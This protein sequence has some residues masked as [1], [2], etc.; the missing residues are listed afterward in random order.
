[1][2]RKTLPLLP[3]LFVATLVA[4]S[5]NAANDAQILS[6]ESAVPSAIFPGGTA[7]VRVRVRNTGTTTWTAGQGYRLGAGRTSSR[8]GALRA[9]GLAERRAPD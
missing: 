6:A 7:T 9:A 8:G 5:A 3:L 4:T 2:I 1:M